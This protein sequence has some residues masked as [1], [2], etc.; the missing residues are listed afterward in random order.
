MS[1]NV[2]AT[3]NE[4]TNNLKVDSDITVI[5]CV[6]AHTQADRAI[7]F[8]ADKGIVVPSITTTERDA[9]TS[10]D[11]GAIIYNSTDDEMNFFYNSQ[12]NRST[13]GNMFQRD[14]ATFTTINTVNI[15]EDVVNFVTGE[16]KE[17]SFA[18]STLITPSDTTGTYMIQYNACIED[19]TTKLYELS[20]E[21]DGTIHDASLSC[22][23]IPIASNPASLGGSFI[24]TI[25]A[26]K[27]VK[28]LV[29]NTTNA[30][31]ILIINSSVSLHKIN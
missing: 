1:E 13:Y 16:V 25:G 5:G 7:K 3:Y 26:S 4:A 31:D 14:N 11:N 27:S 10:P 2:I 20:I 17:V 18:S 15:W 19:G 30:D 6:F 12:W 24:A 21:I 23:T 9:I 29:R 8:E 22:L 28:L